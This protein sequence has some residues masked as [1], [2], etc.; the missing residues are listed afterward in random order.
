MRYLVL[1]S[2]FALAAAIVFACSYG[3]YDGSYDPADGGEGGREAGTVVV[4]QTVDTNGG[5]VRTPEGALEVTF[6]PGTFD[7]PAKIVVARLADREIGNKLIVPVYTVAGDKDP[8]LPFEVKLNGQNPNP[9][10]SQLLAVVQAGADGAFRPLPL[11][12]RSSNTG[13]PSNAFWGL[14]RRLGTF[15]LFYEP[16]LSTDGFFDL[17]PDS[18]I[19]K[20][21]ASQSSGVSGNAG[22]VGS[23]CVCNGDPN[24]SCFLDSCVPNVAAALERCVEIGNT[25]SQT[26]TCKNSGSVAPCS[27]GPPQCGYPMGPCTGGSSCCINAQAGQC[28][29]QGG[30]GSLTCAGITVRCD[31]ASKCPAGTKCCVF[32]NDAYCASSCP[33]ERT[34]CDTQGDCDGGASADGGA[35]AGAN[36]AGPCFAARSCPHGTCGTPPQAC[37]N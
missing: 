37:T 12:S 3:N 14:T 36:D 7:G 21:C 13:G 26:P 8:A 29:G 31:R 32:D 35:D 22:T 5:V 16:V 11:V 28:L 33:N 2:S 6:A 30:A 15:S 25:V 9:N 23:S 19:A 4:T 34:W 24:L 10:P 20:C 18:C 17:S 1:S 27:G